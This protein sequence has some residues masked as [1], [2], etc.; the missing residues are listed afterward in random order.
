MAERFDMMAND[1]DTLF[2]AGR[3]LDREAKEI[4]TAGA[5]LLVYLIAECRFVTDRDAM[6]V[7]AELGAPGPKGFTENNFMC[8]LV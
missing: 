2:G 1:G 7:G 3:A 6:L 8:V 4:E 5:V